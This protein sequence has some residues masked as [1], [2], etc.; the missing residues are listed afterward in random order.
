MEATN[1]PKMDLSKLNP[2]NMFKGGRKSRRQS[3]KSRGWP[4]SRQ[5]RLPGDEGDARK[6]QHK[7][8]KSRRVGRN[9]RSRRVGRTGRTGRK[10]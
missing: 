1:A 2:L 7:G 5:S 9:G 10:Q 3:R 8:G 4:F 6:R